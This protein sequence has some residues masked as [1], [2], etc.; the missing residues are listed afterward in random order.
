MKYNTLL[1]FRVHLAKELSPVTALTYYKALGYLLKDQYLLDC[2]KMN[3]NAVLQKLTTMKY[4]NQYAKYKNAFLKFCDFI[5]LKLPTET[6]MTLDIMKKS[7]KKK[8]RKLKPVQLQDIKNRIKAIRDKKLK[9]SYE[10]MLYSGLRVS[11]LAQIQKED[12]FIEAASITLR[13][14]GKGGGKESVVL[15]ET[16][17]KN[18]FERLKTFIQNTPPT[19]KVFYSASH[20]QAKAKEKGFQCHDLR[21]AFA[22]VTYAKTRDIQ[23]VKRLL[24]HT[25]PKNTRLYLNSNVKI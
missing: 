18:F 16:E 8:Y 12:C 2:K 22:K 1:S 11:E 15:Y 14:I 3:V 20:L 17:N 24:R 21:R 7:K 5:G 13:F 6:L 23:A 4:K 10:T 9:L 19:Q 25:K